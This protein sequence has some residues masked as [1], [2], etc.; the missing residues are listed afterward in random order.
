MRIW[1][2]AD[3]CPVTDFVIREAGCRNIE[4]VLVADYNHKLSGAGAA[5]I[6]VDTAKDSADLR[7]ANLIQKG[8]LLVTQD[9]GAAALALGKG[10]RALN[11]N[12]LVFT[13]EN[14]GELL[15]QRHTGQKIRRMGGKTAA[16]PKRTKQDSKLFGKAFCMLLEEL[17]PS[18]GSGREA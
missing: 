15:M 13:P 1:V 8:D 14:I 11:Q 12:G 3:A 6:V 18:A 7:I 10:A 16:V 5:R 2:D 17:Y 4:V 9:Y